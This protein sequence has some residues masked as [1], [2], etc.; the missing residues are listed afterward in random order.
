[1]SQLAEST[2]AEA[3]DRYLAAW[4]ERDPGRRRVLIAETWT[5]EGYYVDPHR[6]GDGHN[7][8]DAMIHAVQERPP[9][10]G[11]WQRTAVSNR[12]PASSTWAP[13]HRQ[14]HNGPPVRTT[15]PGPHESHVRSGRVAIAW[16]PPRPPS[17]P[18]VPPRRR[19]D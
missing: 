10:S 5:E 8:I 1:M 14:R 3:V 17:A 19:P 15:R 11:S 18:S 4:N 6:R 7:A 13:A 12:S 16:G 2:V 9:T